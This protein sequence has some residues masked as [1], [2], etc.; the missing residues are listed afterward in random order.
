MTRIGAAWR[1]VR[2][3]FRATGLDS[4]ERDAR[5]LAEVAFNR[6]AM[7]LLRDE[8]VEALPTELA[9]LNTLAQRRLKGEP[10]A[11]IIG[12]KAFYGLDFTL[13]AATLVPRPETEM[14]VDAALSFFAGKGG[15]M[16]D[17]GTGTGA[18]PIAVLAN[19]PGVSAVAVDISADAVAAAEDN[20]ARNGVA[21]Q[22]D[23][24]L[25]SWFEPIR[26]GE[27]FDLIVSNPPYIESAVIETLARDVRDFDPMLALD[28]GPDGLA[29]YRVIAAEA[30]RHLRP[31]GAVMLE[32]GADQGESVPALFRAE[33]FA[34]DAAQK[35]L[36]GLDRV[37]IAHHFE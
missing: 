5:L 24:R 37:V 30:K 6:D 9:A 16:L 3:I 13:N 19:A 15:R 35:D 28:G 27:V 7:G 11:R 31:G 26:D 29:P 14:L 21:E 1:N 2:D 12:H 18:I 23:L 22:L 32:I 25:G 20:G 33:G 8:Q 34:V 4:P 17:L 10:V 36:A